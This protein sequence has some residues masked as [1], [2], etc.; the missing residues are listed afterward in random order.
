M[1]RPTLEQYNTYMGEKPRTE[2]YGA[3]LVYDRQKTNLLLMQEHILR[4]DKK[5]W[6]EPVSGEKE[7]ESGKFTRLSNF[8]FGPPVLSFENSNIGS[9]M[10]TLNM[11]VVSGKLTEWSREHGATLPTLVGITNLDPLTAPRVKMNIMLRE[12]KGGVVDEDGR[13][14]L[15]LSDSSGY[16]FEV[17]QWKELNTKLGELIEAKFKAPERGEQIWELNTIAPVEGDLNPTSF[18]VRTHSLAR[19]GNAVASTNQADQEEGAVIVGVA[20]NGAENGNFPDRDERMAYLLPERVSGGAYSMNLILSNETWA[21]RVIPKLIEKME[22]I[23]VSELEYKRDGNGFMVGVSGCQ[24]KYKYFQVVLTA[25]RGPINGVKW[26]ANIGSERG[27]GNLWFEFAPAE[28]RISVLWDATGNVGDLEIYHPNGTLI[29]VM[30]RLQSSFTAKCD[31][32]FENDNSVISICLNNVNVAGS[33]WSDDPDDGSGALAEFTKRVPIIQREL[34]EK[35]SK[36]ILSMVGRIEIVDF[37]RLNG[38]LFR[39]AQRSVMDTLSIPGD[40]SM[41][42]DLAPTLTAFAIDPIEKNLIAGGVQKLT[43]TP[44]PQPGETVTWEVKALPDDSENPEGPEKLGEVVNDVYKAPEA[45]TITGTFRQ[46]IITA[47]VGDSS[48]SALFTIVPKA[49]AVRPQLLN[50]FFSN[51]GSPQRYVLEGGSVDSVLDWTK[52]AGFKGELRDPTPAEYEELNI[53]RD[54]NVKVYVAPERDAESGPVLG[55]L[56]H[57]DQVHVTGGGRMETIDVT[58]LWNPASATVKVEVQGDALKLV[59]NVPSWGGEP[60]DLPPAETKWFVVKGKG[61]LNEAAGTYEPGV[62]EGD[63][64]IIAGV[65][66]ISNSWNYAVLPI[67]YTAEEAK[68][69]HEVNQA[70]KGTNA[71]AAYTAE[72][73]KSMEEVKKNFSSHSV[74][75]A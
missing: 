23:V 57:L 29:G 70:I 10:A 69:F 33:V 35:I 43:L 40:I 68:A 52:G 46:V 56:M 50:A 15:D 17:S 67:P 37:L 32:R 75:R 73:V 55:A 18:T 12:G 8:T 4:A 13:V 72:Q 1:A 71:S 30:A 44:K 38:L 5:V 62:D 64:V 66:P 28:E 31:F 16:S 60:V 42:G 49:V 74:S 9:S 2:G 25:S 41:L 21:R 36:L 6:I 63:Y 45:E 34:E 61:S 14:Y 22:G 65:G 3:L 39:N 48:S 54:K 11:P 51:P 47:T 27:M 24:L 20:F 58:V 53:P 59:L 7:T 26:I 19:A